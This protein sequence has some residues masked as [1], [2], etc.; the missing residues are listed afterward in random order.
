MQTKHRSWN[1]PVFRCPGQILYFEIDFDA[2]Q[3]LFTP[4]LNNIGETACQLHD[5]SHMP[6]VVLRTSPQIRAHS[7]PMR[8]IHS[9]A[10]TA[11]LNRDPTNRYNRSPSRKS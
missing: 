8:T 11:R 1:C 4:L 7:P 10:E 6:D 2:S 3:V 5:D 9:N